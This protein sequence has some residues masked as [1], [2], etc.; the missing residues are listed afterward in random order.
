MN[1]LIRIYRLE[2]SAGMGPFNAGGFDGVLS[3]YRRRYSKGTVYP[4]PRLEGLINTVVAMDG[5]M[6]A[7]ISMAQVYHWFPPEVLPV[8]EAQGFKLR[9]YWIEE[10]QVKI[11]RYQCIVPLISAKYRHPLRWRFR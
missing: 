2:N 9:A 6:C 7:C 3:G 1:R 11:G 5:W 4:S 10:H 8:L